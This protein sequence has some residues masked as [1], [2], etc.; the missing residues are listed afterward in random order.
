LT[1]TGI[2]DFLD[3]LC[4]LGRC[5]LAAAALVIPI[6]VATSDARDVVSVRDYGAAGDAVT[7]DTQAIRRA[8][9]ASCRVHFPS[10]A[11]VVTDGIELPE[12][13]HITG[14]GSPRL[15]TFP[16]D[17]DKRFLCEGRIAHLPGSTLLFRGRSS[18][19]VDTERSD[20]FR[21]LRYAL[22]TASKYP[23][24]LEG[25]GI[26][27][28][29]IVQDANGKATTPKND[30]R[31]D[32]DVGLL[33]DDAARGT[34][35]DVS[36]F[37]YFKRAGLCVLSRSVG[38]NPDYNTFWN[39]S[40]SGEYGVAL[41]GSDREIGPGLSGTQFH[42]CMLF[43]NDHHHRN[44]GQ[45]GSAALFIDGATKAEHADIN[46]HYFFG[47]AIRTY[48]NAAVKLD[49]ASNL[50]FHGVVF[51]VPA[52]AGRNSVGADRTGKVVGTER[53]RDVAFFGCR[54]PNI[55]LN[56]LGRVM[57]D[58]SL[59]VVGDMRRGISVH[60]DGRV[61]R[62]YARP[63]GDAVVQLTK[64]GQSST[65]GWAIR[66]DTSDSQSLVMRYNNQ[67]QAHLTTDGRWR[68]EGTESDYVLAKELSIGR[69][70]RAIISDEAVEVVSSRV[71]LSAPQKTRLIRLNG[72]REGQLLILELAQ[73]SHHVEITADPSGNVQIPHSK[74]LASPF[75]RLTLMRTGDK[76]VELSRS[77]AKDK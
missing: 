71:S 74:L 44:S 61:A 60:G 69:A 28:D 43:A 13:A 70:N 23:F 77:G 25:I 41:I 33:V 14:D 40:F 29:V 9:A 46:G 34:V 65:S 53:T 5:S 27:M 66:L 55:G 18:Q 51:E 42:G 2:S 73:K 45:W 15:G 36:V 59:Y 48:A 67:T 68:V 35:R 24:H 7:D 22:K 57:K 11:Y 47:G 75:D 17:D 50:S 30:H 39:C 63:G 19:T 16:L 76:W 8:L 64:D 54:M 49:R 37:G 52:F 20:G 10:G 32:Y 1:H 26:V 6:V 3:V 62:L 72:G 31:A 56:E 12:S 4:Y 21:T 38:S 58:G